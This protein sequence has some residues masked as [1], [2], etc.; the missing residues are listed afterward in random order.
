MLLFLGL[1]HFRF[2]SFPLVDK[3]VV[4]FRST[5]SRHVQVPVPV[6]IP[7]PFISPGAFFTNQ[8]NPRSSWY[9]T[10]PY[11]F[12]GLV[13]VAASSR[14]SSI[15]AIGIITSSSPVSGVVSLVST[16]VARYWS[17]NK[18]R[19]SPPPDGRTPP[20]VYLRF[21]CFVLR[22]L[23]PIRLARWWTIVSDVLKFTK[24]KRWRRNYCLSKILT[25]P[26]DTIATVL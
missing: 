21:S 3:D 5:Y 11:S 4:D 19:G 9:R 25:Y 14:L 23:V 6:P 26:E 12:S 10:R 20:R 17:L 15:I 7:V 1:V 22:I 18:G 13:V 2:V 8:Q 24:K 16:A